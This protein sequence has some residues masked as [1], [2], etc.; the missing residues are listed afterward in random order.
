MKISL[1][2]NHKLYEIEAAPG[3]SLLDALR[4]EGRL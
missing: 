1:N 2:V 4:D 3:D